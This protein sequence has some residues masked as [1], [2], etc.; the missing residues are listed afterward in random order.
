MTPPDRELPV[1]ARSIALLLPPFTVVAALPKTHAAHGPPD[2][3]TGSA[4]AGTTSTTAATRSMT[5]LPTTILR[6]VFHVMTLT[7]GE[8]HGRPSPTTRVSADLPVASCRAVPLSRA[9]DQDLA[10]GP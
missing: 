6:D 2:A 4:E 8:T 10:D 9:V 7:A 5:T 1:P 3:D